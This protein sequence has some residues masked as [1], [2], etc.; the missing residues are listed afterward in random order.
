MNK[1]PT[2]FSAGDFL[3]VWDLKSHLSDEL[4]FQIAVLHRRGIVL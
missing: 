1:P 4:S 3:A 2:E